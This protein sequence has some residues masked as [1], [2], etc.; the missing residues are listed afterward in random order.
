ME[1]HKNLTLKSS[2]NHGLY[3]GLALIFITLVQYM[4]DIYTTSVWVS[5]I[6]YAVMV[7]AIVYGTIK[8]RDEN[9]GGEI[10]YW[11]AVGYGV[12]ICL[13]SSVIYG[14][15]FYLLVTV[16]DPNYMENLY[17][18]ME[19]AY[20]ESGMAPDQIDLVMEAMRKLQGPLFMVAS[21]IF[22]SVIM[23]TLLSLVTSI[24]I[25]R[26]KPLFN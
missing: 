23:G 5:L 22:G 11:R 26:E 8:H 12:L 19:D 4:L 16:I 2:M 21:S 1:I 24:F 13:F 25:K 3:L 15:F 10:T 17:R 9:L 6:T 14:F 20:Y 18:V 7:A